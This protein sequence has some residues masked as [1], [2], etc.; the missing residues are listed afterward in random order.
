MQ[1]EELIIKKITK[2]HLRARDT[3]VINFYFL[4]KQKAFNMKRI[5]KNKTTPNKPPPLYNSINK[6]KIKTLKNQ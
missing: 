3:V 1:I 4:S 5:N 2:L 6:I